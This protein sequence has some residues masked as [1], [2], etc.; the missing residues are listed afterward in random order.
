MDIE[1][2][3]YIKNEKELYKDLPELEI[4]SEDTDDS[5]FLNA[6]FNSILI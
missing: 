6:L 2:G 5:L 3:N 4:N 1:E